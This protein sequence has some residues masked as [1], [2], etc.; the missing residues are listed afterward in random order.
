MGE[1]IF[2]GLSNPAQRTE[3]L[4][5]RHEGVRHGSRTDPRAPRPDEPVRI[6]VSVGLRQPIERVECL[7]LEPNAETFPLARV[8][9]DWDLINWNYYERWEGELP[10]RA[11]GALV[12]Y[13]VAAHPRFGGPPVLADDGA[14]FSYFVD[15]ARPPEWA[16]SA[17]VYQIFPD[18]FHPGT[19]RSW[20]PGA[21]LADALGGTLRGIIDRLDYIA[22]MGF[23]AIWLNP[24]LPDDNYH[25]YHAQ[26]HFSVDPGVGTLED[27]RELIDRAHALG[28]R[29]LFD[30]VANHWSH[31]HPTFQAAI[32]S[33]DSE[34]RD[35]FFWLHYPHEYRT[36]FGVRELPQVNVDHRPARDYLLSTVRFWL[37]D[38]GFDG[39]RVD[40]A[41]GP[42]HDFWTE[43]R[44]M[45][46]SVKPDAW[47]F[48]EVFDTPDEI[49][50]YE[51]RFDGC[52]D[53]PL[54]QM[55]KDTFVYRSRGVEQLDAF[56]DRHERFFP[57]QFGRLSFLDNHDL[58]RFYWL[59]GGDKRKLR[60]AALCQFTLPGTPVVYYG[61]EVGVLQDRGVDAAA[62]ELEECR[63]PMLWDDDQDA[64]IREYFRWLIQLRRHHPVFWR[65]ARRTLHLSAEAGTYAYAREDGTETI[66]VA[67]NASDLQ[68]EVTV[69][70]RDAEHRFLL[71]PWSGDVAI[72]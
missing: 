4:Q 9:T 65:G 46:R 47:M 29:V 42:T 48:A 44:A 22:G 30:F 7:I 26:D 35:W 53:F 50:S 66:L 57:D 33:P 52:L 55:L 39:L 69:R 67:L 72:L 16:R 5:R 59:V 8:R 23:D 32:R 19:G 1:F 63:R 34:Y 71:E 51:G 25:G 45:V 61:T 62:H 40:H 60:L 6:S 64:E 37:V 31:K 3:R 68:R 20:N 38:V 10:A 15:D 11:R 58:D 17:I 54:L 43:L 13:Q 70:A 49:L 18:R 41:V 27:V 24:F 36:F 2:G 56:L 14:V 21:G 28:L 12:R